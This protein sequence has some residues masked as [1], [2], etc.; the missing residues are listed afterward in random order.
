MSAAPQPGP[1]KRARSPGTARHSAARLAAVQALY[2]ME[3]TGGSPARVVREFELFRLGAADPEASGGRKANQKLFAEL[4]EGVTEQADALD[5]LV[6]PRLA[7]GW[8]VERLEVILR[9]ILRLGAYELR[10]RLEAPARAVI[11]E[12]VKLADAFFSG[13]EPKVVNGVLDAVARETRPGEL[14]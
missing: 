4:V 10:F 13:A 6:A 12:Y 11:T 9:A 1:G 5:A 8:S 3:I 2:Q 14:G 7:E